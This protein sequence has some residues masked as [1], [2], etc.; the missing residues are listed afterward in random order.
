VQI[1]FYT[2]GFILYFLSGAIVI[3]YITE[4]KDRAYDNPFQGLTAILLWPIL[5]IYKSYSKFKHLF[6]KLTNLKNKTK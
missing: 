1:V 6:I 3:Y 5:L 2:L 4:G